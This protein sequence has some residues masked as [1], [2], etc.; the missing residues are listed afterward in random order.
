M[1]ASP[2]SGQQEVHAGAWELDSA[3]W[4]PKGHC[5]SFVTVWIAPVAPTNPEAEGISQG[6]LQLL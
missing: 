1:A 5:T 2:L 3:L 6:W 4:D